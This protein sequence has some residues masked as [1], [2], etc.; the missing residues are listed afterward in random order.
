MNFKWA[1]DPL[2]PF[3]FILVTEALH[4]LILKAKELGFIKSSFSCGSSLVIS[5]LQ[6]ADD[7]ILLLNASVEV[8]ENVKKVLIIF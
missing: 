3:L 1:R 8:L 4:L 5:H 2:S 6:F 7:T